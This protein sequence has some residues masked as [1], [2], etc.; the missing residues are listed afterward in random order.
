MAPLEISVPNQ[1]QGLAVQAAGRDRLLVYLLNKTEQSL[2]VELNLVSNA[3][4][5][6]LHDLHRG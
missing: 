4:N 3:A 5:G 6:I 1:V 2:S